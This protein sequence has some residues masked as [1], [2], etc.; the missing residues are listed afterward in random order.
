MELETNTPISDEARL[1]AQSKKLTLQPVHADVAAEDIPDSVIVA[2][3]LTQG[4]V[5][6]LDID[7]EQNTPPIASLD[8]SSDGL[9]TDRKALVRLYILTGI[10]FVLLAAV[11]FIVVVQP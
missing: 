9:P 4:A 5:G 8:E 11:V 7:T 2:R 1:L 10:G 6:N 3:H